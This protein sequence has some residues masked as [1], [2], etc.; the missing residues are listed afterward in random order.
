MSVP[1]LVM[2]IFEPSTTHAPSRS[3]ARVRVAPGVRARVRL[4]QPERRELACPRRGRAA[5]PLLLLVAEE[6][7][8]HRPERR[9]RG[10]RDR[11]GGVDRAS[12]P[13][14]RSRTRACRAPAPPYS[15]GIG[16]PISPSS[17]ISCDELVR[18]AV[19]AVE[20]R[21]DRRDPL[22]ANSRTVL[23][24]S[25]CSAERSKFTR[26]S[27]GELHDQADAVA[28]P[29]RL[30]EI[31]AA[32]RAQ[33]GRAGDVQVG[34]WPLPGELLEQ[35]GGGLGPPASGTARIAHVG[36][37]RVDHPPVPRIHRHRPRPVAGGLAAPR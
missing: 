37:G 36:E 14:S 8:R 15:S 20:L 13:R 35:L 33:E 2:K 12:A 24:M 30:R 27:R 4:G 28:G 25:S 19:L 32:R 23:R 17:A 5:T 29:A 11:D 16:M 26:R 31:V 34:P 9:V 3:S 6:Q 10:D 18:E 1:A 22:R 7:D 21:C